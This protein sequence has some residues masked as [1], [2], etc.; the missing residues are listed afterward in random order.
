MARVEAGTRQVKALMDMFQNLGELPPALVDS[1][2]QAGAVPVAETLKREA[3]GLNLLGHGTGELARSITV[4]S[5]GGSR[6]KRYIDIEFIG[7]RR[8]GR[9][10][11]TVA[12]FNEFGSRK[13]HARRFILKANNE[14]ATPSVEAM[15]R[16]YDEYIQKG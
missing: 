6:G 13:I 3:A 15:M 10:N 8:G 7:R 1:M 2:L 5:P 16:V 14:S 4:R 11:S 12:F 9:L